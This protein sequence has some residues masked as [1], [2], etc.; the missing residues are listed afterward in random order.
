MVKIKIAKSVL[1]YWPIFERVLLSA[2]CFNAK[3][4]IMN[5]IQIY[6]P[7][8]DSTDEETNIFDE[9]LEKAI[10]ACNSQENIII[11]G[12]FKAKVGSGDNSKSIGPHGLGDKND[13][14][15]ILEAWCEANEYVAMNTWFKNHKRRL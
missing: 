14:G 3:P 9:D 6:A 1:V 10:Q 8:S 12:D 15:M 13:R 11:M 2:V 7:T 5:V 4:F